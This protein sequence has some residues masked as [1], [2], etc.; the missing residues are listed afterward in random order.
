MSVLS[1]LTCRA[2]PVTGECALTLAVAAGME[3]V[4]HA[5]VDCGAVRGGAGPFGDS[6]LHIAAATGYASMPEMRVIVSYASL[7]CRSCMLIG[8]CCIMRAQSL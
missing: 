5:L 8:P 7:L 3:A 2:K 1:P 4:V 6:P